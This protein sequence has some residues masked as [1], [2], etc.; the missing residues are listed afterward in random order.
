MSA[1]FTQGGDVA[2]YWIM[3]P[4]D[5]FSTPPD[6]DGF[7]A[8][9]P[10]AVCTQVGQW[11]LAYRD[12]QRELPPVAEVDVLVTVVGEPGSVDLLADDVSLFSTLDPASVDLDP[13]TD[14]VQSELTVEAGELSVSDG[15][16]TLT[17]ADGFTGRGEIT[18]VVSDAEGLVSAPAM[19]TLRVSEA[20]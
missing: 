7:T 6:S 19:V 13:E 9:C 3:Q 20:G 1:F 5:E 10:S 18:Y 16:L 14:G 15:V 2:L 12:G 11:T 8:Y 17:P 4:R